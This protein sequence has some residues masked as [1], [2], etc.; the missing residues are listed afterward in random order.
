MTYQVTIATVWPVEKKNMSKFSMK[1]EFENLTFYEVQI[2]VWEWIQG[3][4]EFSKTVRWLWTH[5]H[6][7]F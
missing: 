7:F 2:K 1:S 5:S 4:L 6:N 3:N